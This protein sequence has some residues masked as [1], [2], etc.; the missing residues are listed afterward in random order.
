MPDPRCSS[1]QLDRAPIRLGC[2][3]GTATRGSHHIFHRVLA[4]GRTVSAAIVLGK[5]ELAK[6]TT[7]QILSLLHIDADDFNAAL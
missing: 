1:A 2:Y 7:K 3:E 4:D 6:G 5:R